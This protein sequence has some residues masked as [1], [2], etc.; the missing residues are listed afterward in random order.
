MD[1]HRHHFI[2]IENKE[3]EPDVERIVMIG[4]V[5]GISD[6]RI[7]K[8]GNCIDNGVSGDA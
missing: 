1:I 4:D 6:F 3:T 8:I 5:K 7:E 2:G